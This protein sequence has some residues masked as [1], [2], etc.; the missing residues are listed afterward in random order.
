MPRLAIK[1][2]VDTDRGTRDGVLPLARLLAK[3]EV[4]AVFLFSLGPDNMGKSIYR[5]FQPGFFKKVMRT[6]VVSQLGPRSLL[7]GTLFPA[8]LLGRRHQAIMREVKAMGF[9]T[10]IHCHD[11]YR[12]Q[13]HVH[14]MSLEQTRQEFT[15]AAKEYE[16]IFDQKPETAVRRGGNA[17]RTAFRFTMNTNWR[18]PVTR[19]APKLLCHRSGRVTL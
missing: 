9:E 12:W 16:R 11:H 4:P 15:K 17:P 10:G 1:V 13:N 6:R 19:A 7:N 2:D 8:P 18:T 14:R 3:H 5:V